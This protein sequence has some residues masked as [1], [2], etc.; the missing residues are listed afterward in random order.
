MLLHQFTTTVLLEINYLAHEEFQFNYKIK[1]L[2]GSAIIQKIIES[3]CNLL[4]LVDLI[5]EG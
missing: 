5:D 4:A 3:S 2:V 1:Q